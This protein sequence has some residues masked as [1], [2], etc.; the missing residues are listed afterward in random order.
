MK[1]YV[2]TTPQNASIPMENNYTNWKSWIIVI[3]C[4][5]LHIYISYDFLIVACPYAHYSEH[6][7]LLWVDNGYLFGPC[8]KAHN[9]SLFV[10]HG[11]ST[12]FS[13]HGSLA[14]PQPCLIVLPWFVTILFCGSSPRPS[15]DKRAKM[16]DGNLWSHIT[17][18]FVLCFLFWFSF[19]ILEMDSHPQ[20]YPQTETSHPATRL[21]GI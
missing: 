9:N 17:Y 10:L 14:F 19:H 13:H 12:Y 6:L 1:K 20:A 7:K 11:V 18:K 4:S 5:K 8:P 3:F 2:R 21:W 15:W 16:G